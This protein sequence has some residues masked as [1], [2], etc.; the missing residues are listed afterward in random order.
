MASTEKPDA[1]RVVIVGGGIVGCSVAYHLARLGWKDLVLLE[2]TKVSG[3]TTWHAAGLVGRLRTS[4]SMTQINQYSV[5]LYSRLAEETGEPTGWNQVGSIIV[6]RNEERMAQLERTRAMAQI[7]GVEAA[8]LDPAQIAARWPAMRTEDLL[9]AVWLPGDGKVQPEL[10]TK[11]LA[12]GARDHGVDV[13][14]GTRVVDIVREHNRVCG[15][16]TEKGTIRCEQVVLC[17]GMWTRELALRAGVTIPLYPVEHHYAVSAPIEGVHDDLPV[18]REPDASIYFRSEGDSI[19]LGAFQSYTNAWRVPTIPAEFSF[20]L[21]EA[22]WG[23]FEEPLRAGRWRVPALEKAEFPKFVNG[24]ESFT[25]DNNFILGETPELGNLFVAAGF[26]SAGIACA[27]GAGR[28]L[29]EWL[30]GGAPPLDLWSVDPRRFAPFQNNRSFLEK[31][32]TEVVGLHYQMAWP[33]REM[34]SGRGL[35]KTPLH[36]RLESAGAAF[37]SKM[38]WERPNWFAPPGVEPKTEYS[39]GR[40][41]WFEHSAREHIAARET[42]ALFD[43]TGFSK[44]RLRGRDAL[45]LLNRL[46]GADMDVA[47][48]SVVY[49]GMF[50]E[51]GG[52]ESDLTFVRESTESYYV[53]TA[54]GQTRHDY[55]WIVKHIEPGMDAS[56][57]DVTTAFGVLGLMGPRARQVLERASRADVSDAAFP[58]GTAQT[59]DVGCAE[60]RALRVTYVGELGWELHVPIEQ[61]C[62]VFDVLH[63]A[64]ADQGLSNAG[65]YAINSLRLEKA[66]R[67]WGHEIGP[68]DTPLEAGLSFAVAWDKP[69]GFL[70]REALLRQKDAGVSKRLATFV[71]ED[72][73]PVLWGSEPICRDGEVVGFTTSGGYAHTLG[74][75]VA[76]GYVR[77]EAPVGAA[78]VRE[79]SYE[80]ECAGKR[81]AAK[82]YL[83]SPYDPRRERILV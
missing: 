50:N 25:P 31:R 22:D 71:L 58:F 27:G 30:V 36:E 65:H 32:V 2:Q 37:G 67:A 15:V 7:F 28:V 66:Y 26:N 83:R 64:G 76:M 61:M 81:F 79:G 38:G 21:L 42:V 24:P 29:A 47:A 51:R 48:G 33:N 16:R 17:G 52:F 6:G 62:E 3:G 72:P 39:F 11:A 59:I 49:T 19:L 69:G 46:C 53:V 68:D 43:Q 9:G 73:G 77:G 18:V 44:Y 63:I 56:L 54:T 13:L 23:R 41:N 70:G 10:V 34:E 82:V 75:A 5:E 20:E 80:I 8:M 57:A 74:G 14:E 35:R 1:A 40:Q 78:F 4:T 55:D 45:K 12:K 60:V